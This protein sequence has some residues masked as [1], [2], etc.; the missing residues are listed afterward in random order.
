MEVSQ[1]LAIKQM[2]IEMVSYPIEQNF[3]KTMQ[4]F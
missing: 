2:S 3:R 1:V 4:K